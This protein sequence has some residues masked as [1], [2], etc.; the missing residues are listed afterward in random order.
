MPTKKTQLTYILYLSVYAELML[1]AILRPFGQM[2]KQ[3]FGKFNPRERCCSH[4]N[5]MMT[6]IW[7][8]RAFAI[9]RTEYWLVH[10]ITTSALIVLQDLEIGSSEVDTLIRA[11]RCLQE[12][13]GTL[14][15]AGDCLST[16]NAAFKHSGLQAPAYV[17]R[18]LNQAR[19]RKDGLMHH[20]IA[21]LLPT[22]N[23]DNPYSVM[24]SA[25]GPSFQELLGELEDPVVLD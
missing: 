25:W 4:A 17:H 19:H 14:P 10:A 3:E 23:S 12:M 21:A 15:L 24:D 5:R 8:Y 13:M 11:A 22:Q 2:S 20:A 18:Y 16:I 1:T 6:A 7:T 9:L